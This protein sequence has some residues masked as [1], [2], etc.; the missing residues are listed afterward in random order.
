MY[1]I[2]PRLGNFLAETAPSDGTYSE[3]GKNNVDILGKSLGE[4]ISQY[5]HHHVIFQNVPL[6]LPISR[7]FFLRRPISDCLKAKNKE[8]LPMQTICILYEMFSY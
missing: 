3:P 1:I 8:T 5:C 6:K 4:L 2:N 7:I